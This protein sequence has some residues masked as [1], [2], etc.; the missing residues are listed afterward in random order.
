MRA[1]TRP[2][3]AA[4]V[5]L[6]ALFLSSGCESERSD[7]S[8]RGAEART[9]GQITCTPPRR[10]AALP[11]VLV[12]TSGLVL[13][14]WGDGVLWTHNDSGDGPIVYAVDTA[15]S[16]VGR[17]RVRGARAVDW[18]DM[19]KGP[20]ED[21]PCLYLGDIGDNFERREEVTVYRIPEPA[22]GDS[23][24]APAE[25][26]AFSYP[27]GPR[28]AEALAVGPGGDLML[29]TKGRGA[30][31]RVYRID[32]ADLEGRWR[33]AGAASDR[34]GAGPSSDQVVE[35][36][37]LGLPPPSITGADLTPDGRWLIVR[38][39][40]G[41]RFFRVEARGRIRPVGTGRGVSLLSL[42]ELQGEA[43]TVRRDGTIFLTSEGRAGAAPFLSA[44]SCELDAPNG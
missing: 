25:R 41:L 21:G 29:I 16:L 23:V 26:F 1:V 30:P 32:A 12:E 3:I 28:D 18:E 31:R 11:A 35:V 44:L 15:G 34:G 42:G 19:A 14:G 17:V 43:V 7:G 40:T 27:E 39:Y 24:S 22:P 5:L 6:T 10:L 38:T 20:C 2:W 8:V 36:L 9:V 13:S 37:D 33:P 4:T